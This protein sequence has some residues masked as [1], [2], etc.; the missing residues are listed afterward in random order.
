MIIKNEQKYLELLV[1]FQD[2][3]LQ[4]ESCPDDVATHL[5]RPRGEYPVE[6]HYFCEGHY[7]EW[8]NNGV[9]KV[10]EPIDLD[11]EEETDDEGIKEQQ[12]LFNKANQMRKLRKE[13]VT[14][15]C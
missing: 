8:M 14:N 9:T 10:T 3:K 11:I 12:K 7:E 13:K 4:C 5:L 2:H 15:E 6:V 1:K